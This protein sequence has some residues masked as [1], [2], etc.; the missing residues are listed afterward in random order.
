[1]SDPESG[2]DSDADQAPAGPISRRTLIRLLI[3]LGIGIPIAVESRTL[4]GIIDQQFFGGETGDGDDGDAD[5]EGVTVGDE[6]L[7]ETAPVERLTAA[8][9]FARDGDW[10][11]VLEADVTN[12]T[13]RPYEFQLGT[14]E[15]TGGTGTGGTT[16]GIIDPGANTSL[17][18]E[19][20]IPEGGKPLAVTAV[21]IL[22]PDGDAERVS[23]RVPLGNV[24]VQREG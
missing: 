1:M 11:F 19:W 21:G 5:G 2:P 24:P 17:V 14:V 8:T 18:A 9:V 20:S 15:T 4:L 22:D 13:D 10:R 23:E 7:P 6:L 12:T 3:G 16:T